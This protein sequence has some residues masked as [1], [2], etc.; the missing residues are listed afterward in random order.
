MQSAVGFGNRQ[1]GS[2]ISALMALL[3]VAQFAPA[4]SPQRSVAIFADGFESGDLSAWTS[5]NGA[6]T[7]GGS[8]FAEPFSINGVGWSGQWSDIGGVESWEV[9]GGRARLRPV[10]SDYSLARV[11]HPLDN[12][13]D[14]EIR[15][16]VSFEDIATQGVGVYVRQNAGYLEQTVPAG[17][18]YGVFVEGFRGTPG[19]GVWREIGG[20]EQSIQITFDNAL[21]FANGVD[22]RV[23]FRVHQMNPTTTYLQAKVWPLADPEP[24][25]WMVAGQDTTASLQQ[26]SGGIAVDSWSAVQSPGAIAASTFVDDLEVIRL[27]NP[28]LTIPALGA[29]SEAFQ[30]TEGPVWRGDHLL[31]TDIPA[32]T[33]ERLD[34]PAALSTYRVASHEANGLALDLAG[35]LLAAERAPSR[36]SIDDG[37]SVTTRVSQYNG[38]PFNAPNDLAVRSDGIVYFTDPTYGLVG[39]SA[40]GF[41]GLYRLMPNDTVIA[42]WQGVL[43]SNQPNG[44]ALS[45][46]ES[47]LFVSDSESGTVLTW[48]VA[49]DGSLAFVAN[50]ATGLTTPDG[51]CVGPQGDVWI[52]TWASTLEVYSQ[53]GAYWGSLP[54]PQAATNCTFSPTTL[55]VTAQTGLYQSQLP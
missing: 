50:L 14:V 48:S 53:D 4:K 40:I 20:E 11:V 33:I 15:F 24:F 31:F 7:C 25:G 41:A 18:G 22:Y 47:R 51:L 16:T 5:S 44:V 54:V 27:C 28:L 12:A 8:L 1:A 3:L 49:P 6:D 43:G 42:E 2:M 45:P 17:E 38:D 13:Q 21:A 39:P 10:P 37:V 32:A 35:N 36:I 30:F 26:V 29:I 46:D 52:A 19:I 55:Y 9:I 34:P 23:R